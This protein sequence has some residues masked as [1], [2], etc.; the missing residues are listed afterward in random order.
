MSA[1]G[2][3]DTLASEVKGASAK[4]LT[5]AIFKAG[6]DKLMNSPKAKLNRANKAALE[7]QNVKAQL[8][9]EAPIKK[10]IANGIKAA[11][12]GNAGKV[13]DKA[14]NVA[15]RM[16]AP[17]NDTTVAN[18]S[19]AG[20]LPTFGEIAN[21]QIAR[22][23]GIAEGNYAANR[24]ELQNATTGYE[25]AANDYENAYT[26]AEAL[27]AQ[28]PQPTAQPQQSTNPLSKLSQAMDLAM[29]AGDM[30]AW[31]QL[32]DLYTQAAKVYGGSE[33][34][35]ASSPY[36]DLETSQLE[37]INKVDNAANSI[38][39]L[40]AL[41]TQAGGGKGLIGGNLANFQASLGLNNDVNTYNSL[42]QGLIN[43]IMA[44]T[45][46]TDTLNTEAEVRR[47]L[48]LV[49]QFTDTQEVAQ[50]KLNALRQML[51][52]TKQTMLQ[53]YGVAE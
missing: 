17:F 12:A 51:G 47:A 6:K 36:A 39:E 46:K 50:S 31:T 14:V 11:L 42:S 10:T 25:N 7:A 8:N 27:K 30:T 22:Q 53:N 16:A 34:E 35:E 9:G 19:F 23:A 2:F 52:N 3:A 15:E 13:A 41:F 4:S 48:K 45:G 38:D 26:N 28:I 32:A 33:T 21:R 18:A 24:N 5:G 43:Q 29:A 1:G 20:Y 37:N 40:E 49:P 44:A